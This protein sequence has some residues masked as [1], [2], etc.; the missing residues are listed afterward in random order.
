M[1]KAKPWYARIIYEGEGIEQEREFKTKAEAEAYCLGFMD[2]KD[3]FEI[4]TDEHFSDVSQEKAK[5]E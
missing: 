3:L 5:E 1:K 2:T 4:D